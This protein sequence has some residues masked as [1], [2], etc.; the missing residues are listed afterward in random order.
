MRKQTLGALMLFG[1]AGLV[2]AVPAV[3]AAPGPKDIVIAP[4]ALTKFDVTVNN[5]REV[6]AGKALPGLH[7]DE[8]VNGRAMDIY[9]CPVEFAVK[10]GVK[11]AKGDYV[12][13]VGSP[14]PDKEDVFLVREIST[15]LYDQAHNIFRP[16]LTVYL[17]NDDGP[18]WVETSKPID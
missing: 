7:I 4:G 5:I 9:L 18:F 14:A 3:Q 15:G 8:K 16:T 1:L 12:R 10:Y 6:P 17:R 11:V 13:V 2:L